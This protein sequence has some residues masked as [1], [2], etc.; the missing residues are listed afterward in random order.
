MT[1][2]RQKRA[3][4]TEEDKLKLLVLKDEHPDLTWDEFLEL[5]PF[6][7]RTKAAIQNMWHKLRGRNA[8]ESD[9][10]S[11]WE[12][13]SG[14]EDND[15][16][17]GEIAAE[18]KTVTDTAVN[19]PTRG[20]IEYELTGSETDAV[21]LGKAGDSAAINSP[22]LPSKKQ[23]QQRSKSFPA[24]G[25]S[26]DVKMDPQSCSTTLA[27]GP[28]FPTQHPDTPNTFRSPDT[29]AKPSPQ[30]SLGEHLRQRQLQKAGLHKELEVKIKS[31]K[32]QSDAVREQAEAA[33]ALYTKLQ[34]LG[35]LLN[36]SPSEADTLMVIIRA[37]DFTTTPTPTN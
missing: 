16:D 21:D 6:P 22:T 8:E 18:A 5:A 35:G 27:T 28:W 32:A 29:L 9:A 17:E 36:L 26:Q 20:L 15:E 10:D 1:F 2:R 11:E 37:S 31:L 19:K 12:E 25:A 30:L 33:A 23:K 7:G 4:W 3:P 13:Q 34:Q 24:T 14:D